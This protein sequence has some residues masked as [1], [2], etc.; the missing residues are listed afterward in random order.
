MDSLEV[1]RR[2]LKVRNAERSGHLN[3]SCTRNLSLGNEIRLETNKDCGNL[4]KVFVLLRRLDTIKDMRRLKL[5]RSTSKMI[6]TD[7]MECL[8]SSQVETE[9]IAVIGEHP[10]T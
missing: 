1:R 8:F 10:I 3:G 2:D 9:Q 5:N 4:R 7:A 6:L